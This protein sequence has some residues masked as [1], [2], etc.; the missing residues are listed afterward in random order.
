MVH[1][2]QFC[3]CQKNKLKLGQLS[4]QQ[5]KSPHKCVCYVLR[6]F[7]PKHYISQDVPEGITF[8]LEIR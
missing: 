7:Y 3:L 2:V 4:S 8:A 5:I 1:I 6:T